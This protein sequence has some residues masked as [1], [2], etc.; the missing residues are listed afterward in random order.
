MDS[1]RCFDVLF[2][3]LGIVILLPFFIIIALLIKLL[4]QFLFYLNKTELAKTM[5]ILNFLSLELCK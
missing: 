4:R 1:I 5:L 3:F 2:A